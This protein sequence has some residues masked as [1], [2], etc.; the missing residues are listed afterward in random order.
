MSTVQVMGL[1]K[2]RQEMRRARAEFERAKLMDTA[3]RGVHYVPNRPCTETHGTFVYRGHT[4][5][6]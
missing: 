4:Y 1:E 5:V 3:Y 2:A 6:K